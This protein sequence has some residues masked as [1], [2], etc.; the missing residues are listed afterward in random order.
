MIARRPP[1]SGQPPGFN[2]SEKAM[3]MPNSLTAR[4][5]WAAVSRSD[6]INGWRDRRHEG[7][8]LIDVRATQMPSAKARPWLLIGAAV[9]NTYL[10]PRSK[11][12][13]ALAAPEILVEV[14]ALAHVL[15][16]LDHVQQVAEDVCRQLGVSEATFYAWKKK[17]GHLGAT[18][19]RRMRQLEGGSLHDL[20]DGMARDP[21]YQAHGAQLEISVPGL[22][23]VNAQ[24]SPQP[25][26]DVLAEVMAAVDALPQAVRI[27]R[28]TPLA[29]ATRFAC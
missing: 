27:G 24:R 11:I 5:H 17:Y 19:V 23:K 8:V 2:R 25:F 18:E 10:K 15:D 1:S 20:Q 21:L 7:G 9:W 26:W 28:G 16:V 3:P 4:A 13:L 22:S 6:M 29:A 14:E 12:G